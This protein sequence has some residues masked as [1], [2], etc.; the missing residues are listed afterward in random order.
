MMHG[1]N[2][3][4][5]LTFSTVYKFPVI[6][7]I[8]YARFLLWHSTWTSFHIKGESSTLMNG[9]DAGV[10]LHFRYCHMVIKLS[11]I[12]YNHYPCN[13]HSSIV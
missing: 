9:N 5:I 10:F 4:I 12:H 8:K 7:I 2:M 3:K 11:I 1:A 13:N 6:S